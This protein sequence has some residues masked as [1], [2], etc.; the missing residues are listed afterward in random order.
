MAKKKGF[1]PISTI[2]QSLQNQTKQLYEQTPS[3]IPAAPTPGV[4]EGS[5]AKPAAPERKKKPQSIIPRANAKCI[6]FEDEHNEAVERIHWLC[7]SDR[8]D[9]IRTALDHFLTLYYK[10]GELNEEGKTLIQKYFDKTHVMV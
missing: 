3:A 9:I 7:K 4:G 5:A 10:D 8:Q 6:Y 2:E 1:T